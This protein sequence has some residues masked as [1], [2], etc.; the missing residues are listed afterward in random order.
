MYMAIAC[1][2]LAWYMLQQF[3]LVLTL[4]QTVLKRQQGSS[5]FW[6]LRLTYIMWWVIW[7]RQKVYFSVNTALQSDKA[8]VNAKLCYIDFFKTAKSLVLPGFFF[9]QDDA[10]A[11]SRELGVDISN[12]LLR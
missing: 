1:S 3:C 6:N 5:W 8:V 10:P 4:K 11:D 2:L 12:T 7:V 9:Q